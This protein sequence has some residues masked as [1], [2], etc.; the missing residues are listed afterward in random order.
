MSQSLRLLSFNIQIGI[1]T[2]H[3]RH[4]L[5][6]GWKHLLDHPQRFANLARMAEL[7]RDYDLVG[8][9]ETDAGSARSGFVNLTCY[10]AE[11]GGFPWWSE[12][13]NRRIG[14]LARHS[15]GLLSRLR[16]TDMLEHRLPGTIAGRGVLEARFGEGQD[17]LALFVVHLALS[18]RVRLRQVEFLA[19]LVNR[20][21]HVI[22]MGD[23]NCSL[24]SRELDRLL[25]LTHLVDPVSSLATWPSWRP[26]QD[27]DH[28]LLSP[29]LIPETLEVLD[30]PLSDHLPIALRVR[31][32]RDLS[33]P[34]APAHDLA[35]SSGNPISTS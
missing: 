3:Y 14:R 30:F 7:M 15:L 24:G 23:M 4:Y 1:A 25:R 9:Q 18:R 8:I 19:G 28:I 22:L 16:P 17:G 21:R 12:R 13:V 2:R 27:L 5:L 32:P 33:L 26:R 20:H 34:S 11:A 29:G 31:L 6:H 35:K 10:L